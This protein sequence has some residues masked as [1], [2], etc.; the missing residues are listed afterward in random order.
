MH[1]FEDFWPHN[2]IEEVLNSLFLTWALEDGTNYSITFPPSYRGRG[3][4]WN[5]SVVIYSVGAPFSKRNLQNCTTQSATFLIC[6][7]LPLDKFYQNKQ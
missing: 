2:A 6:S 3:K 7:L 5:C 1:R 4:I